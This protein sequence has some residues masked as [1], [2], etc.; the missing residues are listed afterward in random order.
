M[1][2]ALMGG[3]R[4]DEDAVDRVDFG[5]LDGDAFVFSDMD[6]VGAKVRLNGEVPTAAVD[7][8]GELDTSGATEVEEFGESCA[9]AAAGENDFVAEN[10]AGTI[11]VERDI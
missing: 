5:E 7:Q 10:D 3:G 11:D 6:G 9:G 1:T 4:F 8:D 2:W